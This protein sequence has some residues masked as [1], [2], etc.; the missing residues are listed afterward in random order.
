MVA[1]IV[2]ALVTAFILISI[3]KS[4]VYTDAINDFETA[5]LS[6]DKMK[7]FEQEYIDFKG[8]VAWQNVDGNSKN[9]NDEYKKTENNTDE[10]YYLKN[11]LVGIAYKNETGDADKF[12]IITIGD[13]KKDKNNSNIYS[14]VAKVS[15]VESGVASKYEITFVFYKD[16]IIDILT[17]GYS[18]FNLSYVR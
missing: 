3:N 1:I 8:A 10:I 4:E 11:N 18:L 17:D 15:V 6:Q 5:I 13:K 16:K 14:V 12:E 2:T 7:K 9:F